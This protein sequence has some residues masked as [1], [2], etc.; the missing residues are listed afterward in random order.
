MGA[1][2]DEDGCTGRAREGAQDAGRLAAGWAHLAR[3]LTAASAASIPSGLEFETR[4]GSYSGAV[5]TGRQGL[6]GAGTGWLCSLLQDFCHGLLLLALAQGSI[7]AHIP[8]PARPLAH[9][10]A[11]TQPARDC[12]LVP[13]CSGQEMPTAGHLGL[14]L[15]SPALPAALRLPP[16]AMPGSCSSVWTAVDPSGASK[17]G[18]AISCRQANQPRQAGWLL[19]GAALAKLLENG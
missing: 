12:N 19:L 8:L 14:T 13:A 18:I 10:L 11:V 16:P 3:S 5:A 17:P 2:G 7:P 4:D 15:R 9:R 1:P 6:D